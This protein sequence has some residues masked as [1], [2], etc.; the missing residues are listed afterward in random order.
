[1]RG[2]ARPTQISPRAF[3]VYVLLAV[4]FVVWQHAAA[5]HGARSLPERIVLRVVGPVASLCSSAVAGAGDVCLS[6]AAAGRLASENKQLRT[7]LAQLRAQV[8]ELAECRRENERLRHLLR[9]PMPPNLEFIGL[10]EVIGRSPGLLNRRLKLRAA[11][12]VELARDD[13]ILDGGYLAGRVLDAAGSIAEAVLIV[14]QQHAVAVIDQRSRDQGMLYAQPASKGGTSLLRLEKITG[15][16]DVVVGDL[17]LTSGLGQVYP[18]G[19]PVGRVI[20][21]LTSPA[22]KETI[23]AVVKPLADVDRL[24]LVTVARPRV[25]P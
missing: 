6:L 18:K 23:A 11:A 14:D 17:L 21:V 25:Q 20:S 22:G 7:E 24:E 9:M 1:M 2:P 12:G 16:K 15:R 13:I 4:V 10:A 19:I 3:I 8:I 5:A